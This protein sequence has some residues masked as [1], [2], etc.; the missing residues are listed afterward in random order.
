MSPHIHLY[1]EYFSLFPHSDSARW[2][3]LP[4]MILL[5]LSLYHPAEATTEQAKT[6]VDVVVL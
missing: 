6:D 4:E 1:I 2:C 3:S 5:S